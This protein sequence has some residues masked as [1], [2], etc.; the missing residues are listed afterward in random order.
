MQQVGVHLCCVTTKPQSMR[1]RDMLDYGTMAAF[2]MYLDTD[3]SV[4]VV[5]HGV[6][7]LLYIIEVAVSAAS[8]TVKTLDSRNNRTKGA[9]ASAH[10]MQMARY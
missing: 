3:C 2:T 1:L 10:H 7:M 4:D 6:T 9:T 8:L 5:C